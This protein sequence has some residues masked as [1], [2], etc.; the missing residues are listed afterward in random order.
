[1][2]KKDHIVIKSN[3]MTEMRNSNY[4]LAEQRLLALYL[5]R[6]NPTDENKSKTVE[7]T[8]AEFKQIL[9]LQNNNR[10]YWQQ[11]FNSLVTKTI[12][13]EYSTDRYDAW[14]TSVVFQKVVML[15]DKNTDELTIELT[16]SE[17][18]MPIFFDLK[19]NYT[20]YQL[21]NCL[22]LSSS[23]QIRMYEIL[24]QY[25]TVSRRTI[26][27]DDLKS[28]LGMSKDEYK[29]W[30]DFK[31]RVIEPC[32]KS[33]K[34]NTDIYFEYEPVK[35][36]RKFYSIEF[37]IY[38]NKNFKSPIELE[39]Y[40]DANN[41]DTSMTD[42]TD[43]ISIK[44]TSIAAATEYRFKDSE[45]AELEQTLSRYIFNDEEHMYSFLSKK[46]AEFKTRKDVKYPF[47]YFMKIVE[48]NDLVFKSNKEKDISNDWFE[49]SKIDV[50]VF[51]KSKEN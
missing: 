46:Y 6:I 30:N 31:I 12:T 29:V 36:G 16:A 7:F 49:Q 27:I 24:K 39:D 47:R 4:T 2:L 9:G 38:T 35:K 40:I 33:L 44:D 50:P 42:T 26:V 15:R 19:N 28:M 5:S 14:T 51:K 37:K 23:N 17:D 34:E 1:M 43:L 41:I 48:N 10:V 45:V 21:W 18:M 22:R 3:V 8:F 32:K 13:Y 25:Q 11:A 20:K